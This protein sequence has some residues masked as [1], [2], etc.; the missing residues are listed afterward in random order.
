MKKL[1]ALLF[2][3]ALTVAALLPLSQAHAMSYEPTYT[4]YYRDISGHCMSYQ[5]STQY[6][7]PLKAPRPYG[8][9]TSLTYPFNGMVNAWNVRQSP[10][11]N[12]TSNDYNFPSYYKR[13]EDPYDDNDYFDDDDYMIRRYYDQDDFRYRT[14]RMQYGNDWKDDGY[15]YGSHGNGGSYNYEHTSITCTGWNCSR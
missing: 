10:W 12:R 5:G 7:Y 2:T 3:A 14:Y 6:V 15:W 4:C 13:F 11:D 9:R 1:P 8:N